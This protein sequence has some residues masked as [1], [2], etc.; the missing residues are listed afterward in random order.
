MG[1]L[2]DA[3]GRAV[4]LEADDLA[5]IQVG[6]P[7]VA[8]LVIDGHTKLQHTGTNQCQF[9][10]VAGLAV[11]DGFVLHEGHTAIA[12]ID[13]D[14]EY[15]HAIGDT[16]HVAV[17]VLVEAN[18]AASSGI[19]PRVHAVLTQIQLVTGTRCVQAIRPRIHGEPEQVFAVDTGVAEHIA[20]ALLIVRRNMAL[21]VLAGTCGV[22]RFVDVQL[23]T[24]AQLELGDFRAVVLE[25]DHFAQIQAGALR[26]AVLVVDGHVQFQHAILE[27][28]QLVMVAGITMRDGLVLHQGHAAVSGV[29]A[30]LEHRNAIGLTQNAAIG[31]LVQQNVPTGRGI[32]PRVHSIA[33][34]AQGEPGTAAVQAIGTAIGDQLEKIL[35]I[36]SRIPQHI[37]M[38]VLIV[39]RNMTLL[40]LIGAAFAN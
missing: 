20:V 11:D 27:Q 13:A 26:V 39:R 10:M 18:V 40:V 6:A 28:R 33:G 23:G 31:L 19:Q 3:S 24:V 16:Q 7:R 38:A 34:K 2:G 32:Q 21:L 30:D 1:R 9:V 15:G 12:G 37:A 4:V 36:D 35:A 29:D 25:A 5:Q 14:L 8:V 22:D 17:T